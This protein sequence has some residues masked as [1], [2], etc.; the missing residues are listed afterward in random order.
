MFVCFAPAALY[1]YWSIV[2][3]EGSWLWI[4]SQSH[5]SLPSRAHYGY[6]RTLSDWCVYKRPAAVSITFTLIG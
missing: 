2:S 1:S 4:G 5:Y 6:V 3:V